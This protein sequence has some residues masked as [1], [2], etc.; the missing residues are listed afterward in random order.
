MGG[1]DTRQ[2][3]HVPGTGPT[4]PGGR[5]VPDT[6]GAVGRSSPPPS[7]SRGQGKQVG[8]LC[9]TAPGPGAPVPHLAS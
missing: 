8:G 6:A 3:H 7:C 2:C 4:V 9:H 1:K 5:G